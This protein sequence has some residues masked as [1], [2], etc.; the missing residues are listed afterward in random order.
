MIKHFVI[1]KFWGTCSFVKMLKG[2][3]VRERMGTPG[4][5]GE[6]FDEDQSPF[7]LNNFSP[8]SKTGTLKTSNLTD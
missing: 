4:L 6:R 3:M 7:I 1:R 2:Y 5:R 8:R